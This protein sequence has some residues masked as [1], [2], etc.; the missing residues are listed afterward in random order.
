MKT[1]IYFLCLSV[2]PLF[3]HAQTKQWNVVWDKNPAA[4]SVSYYIVY[5]NL[6]SSPTLNDSV[7]M[8]QEPSNTSTQIVSYTDNGL[9]TGQQYFYRVQAVDYKDRRS[10]LSDAIN[11]SIPRILISNTLTLK[12]STTNQFDL[13]ESQY[14]SYPG[15]ANSTLEWTVNGGSKISAQINSSTNVLTIQTPADSTISETLS[16]IAENPNGF[17]DQ[18]SVRINLTGS[19]APPPPPPPPESEDMVIT[20]NA[21]SYGSSIVGINWQTK[22]ETKDYIQYGV[23][24]TFSE[25][26]LLDSDYATEHEVTLSQLIPKTEYQYRIVSENLAGTVYTSDIYNFVAGNEAEINV[27]P[28]PYNVNDPP[29]YG[30]IYFDIPSNEETYTLQIFTAV[31]DLVYSISDLRQS[32]V[33]K[34]QN[35]SGREVNAGLYLYQ[36]KG[37]ADNKV[38]S[39]KLVIIR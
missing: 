25:M 34:V 18:K 32:Y 24:N 30:G 14:V 33:W 39:G 6:G 21:K 36:I 38:A 35:S 22:A 31:G 8:S 28:I 16:L 13:D 23:N 11:E 15:Y 37:S 4:D 10:L 7:A 9:Q 3:L 17:G 29:E 26:S 2:A 27:F 20:V 1:V 19:T 5:R 12:I